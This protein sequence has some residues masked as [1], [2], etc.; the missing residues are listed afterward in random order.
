MTGF[1][2][3]VA[4]LTLGIG[5]VVTFG[6]TIW[7]VFLKAPLEAPA[8]PARIP[9][10]SKAPWYF[11]G[12]QE[13]LVYFDPWMAGVVLP[14]MIIVGLIAMPYILQSTFGGACAEA[15]ASK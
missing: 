5:L 6:L 14:T 4:A 7:A 12:L 3:A 9:N 1:A 2:L 8:S 13:M 10:P 11:L 15:G